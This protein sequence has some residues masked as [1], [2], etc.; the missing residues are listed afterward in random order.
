MEGIFR[1]GYNHEFVDE[2]GEIFKDVTIASQC[3]EDGGNIYVRM[4]S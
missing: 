4:Q 2:M 3:D 1:L